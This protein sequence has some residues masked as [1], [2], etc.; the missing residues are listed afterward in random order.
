[1]S[2][3]DRDKK[4]D[5]LLELVRRAPALNGGFNKLSAAVDNI[6][7]TNIKVLYELQLLKGGQDVHTKKID[8]MH[9]SLYD[10]DDGLYQR[11]TSAIAVNKEQE[12]SL[13]KTELRINGIE[14]SQ[15]TTVKKIS[16]L[17]EKH[18]AIEHIA[19][20]DL[21]ELRAVISIRKDMMRA[22]WIFATGAIAGVAKFMWDIIPNLF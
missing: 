20:K 22:F 18:S 5:E 19:G 10:P 2:E 11:V 1:M 17:E 15:E 6:K 3:S 16:V 4:L 12:K 13:A 21:Q 7:E 9:K 14:N 8:D